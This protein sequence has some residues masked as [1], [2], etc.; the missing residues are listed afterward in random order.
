MR[1]RAKLGSVGLAIVLGLG[2]AGCCCGGAGHGERHDL[3]GASLSPGARPGPGGGG[4]GSLGPVEGPG[5]RPRDAAGG[6]LPK[7]AGLAAPGEGR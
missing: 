2:A 6:R 5:L 1:A 7:S 4:D 3:R